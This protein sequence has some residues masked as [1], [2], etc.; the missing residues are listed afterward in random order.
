L[1]YLLLI[2]GW[3]FVFLFRREDR[4]AVYHAKQALLLTIVAGATPLVWAVISWVV[5]WVPWVGPLVAAASFSLV[6]L[7][8]VVTV[9]AWVAGMVYALQARLKPVPV[10]GRWAE[11]LP[12]G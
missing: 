8:Y 7:V 4:F 10:L 2:I 3:L 12:I 5:T 1:S 11:R 9:V 6:M